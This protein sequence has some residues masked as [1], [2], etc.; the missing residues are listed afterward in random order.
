MLALGSFLPDGADRICAESLPRMRTM[1]RP[2]KYR[3]T[4]TNGMYAVQKI[5]SIGQD[6]MLVPTGDV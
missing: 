3:M 1:K 4:M 2:A 5:A 6:L